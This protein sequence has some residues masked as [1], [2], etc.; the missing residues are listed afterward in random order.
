[1]P[2]RM[3]SPI[4]VFI[5]VGF[6]SLQLL[7]RACGVE[8]GCAAKTLVGVYIC[9]FSKQLPHIFVIKLL[10]TFQNTSFIIK[11]YILSVYTEKCRS[12]TWH[13]VWY[14]RLCQIQH[15]LIGFT[16]EHNTACIRLT[17]WIFLVCIKWKLIRFLREYPCLLSLSKTSEISS[18]VRESPFCLLI[19]AGILSALDLG[20]ALFQNSYRGWWWLPWRRL[21]VVPYSRENVTRANAI[22]ISRHTQEIGAVKGRG[23][24]NVPYQLKQHSMNT[25]IYKMSGYE[26][27][28]FSLQTLWTFKNRASYI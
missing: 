18:S 5:S 6:V 10:K 17:V 3:R 19:D 15:F 23:C 4:R 11:V 25:Y 7:A 26:V 14:K 13:T 21:L 8:L 1:M 20:C 27:N 22:I 9:L 24:N 16:F 28:L 12:W 2:W